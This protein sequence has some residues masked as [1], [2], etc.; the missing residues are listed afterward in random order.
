MR[1][2][3][4]DSQLT[5]DS[6]APR[7]SELGPRRHPLLR[8]GIRLCHSI[9]DLP[10]IARPAHPNTL[11]WQG[12]GQP[13]SEQAPRDG[14]DQDPWARPGL[15]RAAERDVCEWQSDT[16]RGGARNISEGLGV[17]FT[18]ADPECRPQRLGTAR[19]DAL[20]RDITI[21]TL[22]YNVHSRTIE[23]WT[24][25]GL[26]DMAA[27][28]I[29]TP[30][31]PTQTFQDDPLRILRCIRFASRFGYELVPELV[32]SLQDQE[33]LVR[34]GG[35]WGQNMSLMSAANPQDALRTRISR[36]RVGI[37]VEKML[38]GPDPLLSI[39]LMVEHSLFPHIFTIPPAPAQ[40]PYPAGAALRA[41]E[42]FAAV[43]PGGRWHARVH[44]AV[45]EKLADGDA[46]AAAA[47]KQRRTAVWLACTCAPF[48]GGM[49]KDKKKDVTMAEMVIK[50]GLKVGWARVLEGE[51]DVHARVSAR[52]HG[53]GFGCKAV[54]GSESAQSGGE[55]GARNRPPS[56][57][58]R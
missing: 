53:K 34:H 30:L 20:R 45:L 17:L 52:Q 27:Q 36:E 48:R 51:P 57:G 29:R 5:C 13:G 4:H 23:D 11:D 18:R 22:F 28:Q 38:K 26:S 31:E 2:C 54:H 10:P 50:E 3:C 24:G 35:L 37:E 8:V 16:G 7:T 14:C 6:L 40:P 47:T 9:H 42:I 33:I 55:G 1:G 58:D 44:P 39:R 19:E 25:R 49:A 41:A 21:N 56:V 32:A 12:R 43:L 15:R 46:E